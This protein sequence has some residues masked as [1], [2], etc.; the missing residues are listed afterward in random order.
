MVFHRLTDQYRM[1]PAISELPSRL[2]YDRY[3]PPLHL[4]FTCPSPSLH[5]PFTFPA[6]SL[7]LPCTCPSPALHLPCTCPSPSLHLPPHLYI[8]RHLPNMAAPSSIA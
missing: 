2:F 3:V 4:P 1:H 7:H 6:P 5:L 8:E